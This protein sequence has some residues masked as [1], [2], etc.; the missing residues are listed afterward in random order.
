MRRRARDGKRDRGE[1]FGREGAR[2]LYAGEDASEMIARRRG[3]RGD[4]RPVLLFEFLCADGRERERERVGIGCGY[5]CIFVFLG[6]Q[7]GFG[8]TCGIL[9]RFVDDRVLFVVCYYY[10]DK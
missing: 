5:M 1:R 4:F 7:G 2:D 6:K 9:G 10:S 8:G 3:C